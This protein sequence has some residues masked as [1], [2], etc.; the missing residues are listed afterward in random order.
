VTLFIILYCVV[1]HRF[2]P[3]N[4][5]NTIC[6]VENKIRGLTKHGQVGI[7]IYKFKILKAL[8]ERVRFSRMFQ[9]AGDGASPV[10]V[11]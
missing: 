1:G 9:R 5:V 2:G 8:T 6:L 4:R 11:V 10:P 3:T 7:L